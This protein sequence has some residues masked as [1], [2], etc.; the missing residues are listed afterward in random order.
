M[1]LR[2]LL[3][4]SLSFGLSA[5]EVPVMV[6]A[7]AN[8]AEMTAQDMIR[9]RMTFPAMML[10]VPEQGEERL[11]SGSMLGSANGSAR[12]T[13]T[14]ETGETCTGEVSPD[15]SGQMTCS[16]SGTFPMVREDGERTRMSGVI[17]REGSV[18]IEIGEVGYQLAFGW[19]RRANEASLRESISLR[20]N[21]GRT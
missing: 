4:V 14:S 21:L 12:I 17:Y 15:G 11:F 19:G 6:A 3:F 8:D 10:V 5:C 9:F 2:A 1:K 18:N 16:E 20:Q 13:L 7:A